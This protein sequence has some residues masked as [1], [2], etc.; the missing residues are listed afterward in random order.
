M[1]PLVAR[2]RC[3]RFAGPDPQDVD[4]RR[5]WVVLA[6]AA[7]WTFTELAFDWSLSPTR[8]REIHRR[9]LRAHRVLSAQISSV[10]VA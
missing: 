7:G 4:I 6:I 8:I 3:G 5:L 1:F 2:R 9:G 10:G